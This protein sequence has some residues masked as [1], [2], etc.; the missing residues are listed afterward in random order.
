MCTGLTIVAGIS[1]LGTIIGTASKVAE[2]G[3]Q[4][5]ALRKQ[6]TVDEENAARSELM[7]MDALRGAES[8]AR[9]VLA[10]AL[11]VRARQRIAL[12]AN[13]ID[14]TTGTPAAF[15]EGGAQQASTA[16]NWARLEG[17][18]Q[19]YGYHGN[20]DNYRAVA[21]ARRSDADSVQAAGYIGAVAS[22]GMGIAQSAMLYGQGAGWFNP[23]GGVAG[24]GGQL[25]FGAP[26]MPF[27]GGPVGLAPMME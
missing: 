3:A 16:A 12:G 13:N 24:A 25:S 27:R 22:L 2:A 21:G 8:S 11:P 10:Q 18:R 9:D 14:P 19:A 5:D 1:L 6:A 20:A 7:S 4:S 15:Q 26:T 17:A 23:T